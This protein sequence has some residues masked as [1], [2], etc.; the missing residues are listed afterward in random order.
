M[1]LT[2]AVVEHWLRESMILYQK[3]AA[4]EPAVRSMRIHR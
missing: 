4:S 1:L 2:R 3:L